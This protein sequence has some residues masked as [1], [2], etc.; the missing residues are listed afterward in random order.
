MSKWKNEKLNKLTKNEQINE[1][2]QKCTSEWKKLNRNG[3]NESKNELI[4]K[5]TNES[6]I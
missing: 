3:T 2:I 4:N 6:T 5:W 1:E